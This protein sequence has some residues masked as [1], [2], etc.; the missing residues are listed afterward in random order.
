MKSYHISDHPTLLPTTQ[1]FL[2]ALQMEDSN[3]NPLAQ[4]DLKQKMSFSYHYHCGVWQLVYAMV[5]C[6]PDLSFATAKLSHHNTCPGRL[7]FEG[8]HHALKYLYQTWMEGL[9]FWWTMPHNELD[10]IPLPHILSKEHDLLCL[11][12]KQHDT[13]IAHGMSD[14]DWASCI[15]TC[16]SF[17]GSLIKLAGAAVAYKT[18]LQVTVADM[19]PEVYSNLCNHCYRLGM[20]DP[21]P[22]IRCVQFLPEVHNRC[23][24]SFQH[25]VEP[26]RSVD[27]HRRSKTSLDVEYGSTTSLNVE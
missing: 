18:Q 2:K 3:P 22:D 14:A 5:C 4:K 27:W 13:H 20:P 15:H 23:Q 10:S 26:P 16:H 11:H 9:Y 6:H 19:S 7:H 24:A 25:Q 1:S 8:V 17:M 21:R 12:W